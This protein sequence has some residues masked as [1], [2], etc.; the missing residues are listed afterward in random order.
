MVNVSNLNLQY[1]QLMHKCAYEQ[2]L[3]FVLYVQGVYAK[4]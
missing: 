1:V 3:T 2:L 4:W